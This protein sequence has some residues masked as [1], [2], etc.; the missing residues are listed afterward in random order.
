MLLKA[1]KV[2]AIVVATYIAGAFLLGGR[3][4]LQVWRR[5]EH[6]DEQR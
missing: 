6:A 5:Y 2:A 4:R 3:D 1:G